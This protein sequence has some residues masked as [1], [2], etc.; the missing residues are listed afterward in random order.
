MARSFL[1]QLTSNYIVYIIIQFT[2]KNIL[3]GE[4]VEEEV[5]EVYSL[6]LSLQK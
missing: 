2:E 3:R 6:G 4:R 1:V 5:G